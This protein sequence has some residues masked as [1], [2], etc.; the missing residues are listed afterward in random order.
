MR[1]Q[2]REGMKQYQTTLDQLAGAADALTKKLATQSEA[3][4]EERKTEVEGLRQKLTNLG[5]QIQ[6]DSPLSQRLDRFEQWL[7]AQRS[8]VE[9]QRSKLGTEFVEERLVKSYKEMQAEVGTARE[10]LIGGQKSI[11]SLLNELS[12]AEDRIAELLLAEDAANAVNELREVVGAIAKTIE[13][14]RNQVRDQ[15]G[16]SGV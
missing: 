6:S 3:T 10:Q 4:V 11:D 7:T 13:G 8:R 1:E 2:F 16:S 12:R 15:F 14:I 9:N 5:T